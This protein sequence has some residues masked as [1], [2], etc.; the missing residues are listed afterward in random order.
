MWLE[1]NTGPVHKMLMYTVQRSLDF[2]LNLEG[3]H[4]RISSR[5]INSEELCFRKKILEQCY[6]RIICQMRLE[7]VLGSDEVILEENSKALELG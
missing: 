6:E 5:R 1:R 4:R 7:S 3:K 2:I